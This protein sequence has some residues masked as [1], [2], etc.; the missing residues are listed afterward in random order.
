MGLKENAEFRLKAQK[1]LVSE[2]GKR[3]TPYKDSRGIF[4]VGIG[5]N[6]EAKPLTDEEIYFIFDNDLDDSIDAACRTFGADLYASFGLVR[7]LAIVNMI[8]Q[9]GEQGFNDFHATRAAIEVKDWKGAADF[10]RQSRWARQTPK[11]A[12]RVTF[13]LETGQFPKQ[14]NIT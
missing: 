10:A 4:T 2:E 13:M 14:Y 5:H 7:Q 8:F 6:C 9:L 3:G 1:M 11:R 12:D